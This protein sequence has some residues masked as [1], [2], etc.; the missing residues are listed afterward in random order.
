VRQ[1]NRLFRVHF[2]M[3]DVGQEK[4][5]PSKKQR[6]QQIIET[7]RDHPALLAYY[8]ADEPDGPG[9]GIDPSIL[10]DTYESIKKVLFSCPEYFP[11]NRLLSSE[12]LVGSLSSDH[13]SFELCT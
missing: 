9:Y 2:S 1:T 8:I 12:I 13:S 7:L 3:Y 4:P 10:C 11:S 6:I 5:S